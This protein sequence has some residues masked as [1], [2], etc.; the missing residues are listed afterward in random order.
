VTTVARLLPRHWDGRRLLQFLTGLALIALAFAVP[1]LLNPA[2]PPADAPVTVITTVDTPVAP[3][4][5]VIDLPAPAPAADTT[6][7]GDAPGGLALDAAI[8]QTDT[9]DAP[10]GVALGAGTAQTGSAAGGLALGAAI[11]QTDAGSARGADANG[12]GSG[13][14]AGVDKGLVQGENGLPVVL[15]PHGRLICSE[16]RAAA[17]GAVPRTRSERG[18][19]QA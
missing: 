14:V 3:G 12:S 15:R 17:G 5:P 6:T 4:L 11:A 9:G 2:A 10:A 19:P 1:A 7:P 18:P 13:N 16:V 8:A